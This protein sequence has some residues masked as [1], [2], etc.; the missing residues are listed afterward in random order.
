MEDQG[1]ELRTRAESAIGTDGL[2]LMRWPRRGRAG[3]G[4]GGHLIPPGQPFV[5]FSELPSSAGQSGTDGFDRPAVSGDELFDAQIIK[6]FAA[7]DERRFGRQLRQD[8][9]DKFR[10]FAL[11]QEPRRV[12]RL[13][14]ARL[15]GPLARTSRRLNEPGRAECRA[16]AFQYWATW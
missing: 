7:E 1:L 5:S 6:V 10:R 14:G 4:F 2:S 12:V 13:G 9:P 11:F 16:A 3:S 8:P 15:P